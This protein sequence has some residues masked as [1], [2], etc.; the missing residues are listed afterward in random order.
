MLAEVVRLDRQHHRLLAQTSPAADALQLLA[1]SHQRLV[2]ERQRHCNQLR[3]TLR[4]FYPA[5]LAAFATLDAPEARVILRHAPTPAQGRRLTTTQLATLLRRAGRQR[6]IE[7]AAA[8][9]QTALRSTYL[10]QPPAVAAAGG[11]VVTALV[12]IIDTLAVQAA[13][14]EA[15]LTTQFQAHPDAELL[16]SLPGL[17]PLLGARVL[18][19]RG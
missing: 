4:E 5:A 6:R 16:L 1:R 8:A 19:V 7:E 3:I 18:A 10:E 12:A 14:L 2:W 15:D 9:I 17:G 11:A 13:A